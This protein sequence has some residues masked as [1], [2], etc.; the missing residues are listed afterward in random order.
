MVPRQMRRWF[1]SGVDRWEH[2]RTYKIPEA[3]PR[4]PA[5]SLRLGGENPPRPDGLILAGDYTEFGAIQGAMLSGRRAAEEILN[6][7]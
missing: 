1:G 5:G 7:R 2:L 3:L 4:H 6:R